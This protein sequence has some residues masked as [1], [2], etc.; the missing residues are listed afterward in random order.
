[1]SESLAKDE[2][3]QKLEEWAKAVS[4]HEVVEWDRMPE[5]Y[6]YMDQVLTY[7]NRQLSFY[8]RSGGDTPLTSSMINNY[9][10]D[11]ILDRP[12]QKKYGRDH[13]AMLTVIC[14]LKPVL[15]IQDISTLL[16]S[17]LE[18]N[19]KAE[20]YQNFCEAQTA[21]FQ[22]ICGRMTEAAAK[23]KDELYRLAVEFSVE[24]RARRSAAE[25]ILS[26]LEGTP[27]KLEKGSKNKKKAEPE[28]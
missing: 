14:L 12:E 16:K 9:V 5:I 19:T 7:M 2:K 3:I 28:I 25:R 26:E 18:R 13:L 20:L 4:S 10:K 22:D 27:L 15:S 1:M 23:G 24:A 11:G 8:E 17:M 21:A 6:L